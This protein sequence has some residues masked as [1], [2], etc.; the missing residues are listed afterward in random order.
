MA[1]KPTP[2]ALRGGGGPAEVF[3]WWMRLGESGLPD[4]TSK[5][6]IITAKNVEML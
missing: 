6:L 1:V 4:G 3:E 5:N 2:D